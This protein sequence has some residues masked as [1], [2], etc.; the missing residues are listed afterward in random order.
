MPLHCF[1]YTEKEINGG[2]QST[3]EIMFNFQERAASCAFKE[4]RILF[5]MTMGPL[6][7]TKIR[8]E[9]SEYN[10]TI[11]YIE[12]KKSGAADGLSRASVHELKIDTKKAFAITTRATT[13]KYIKKIKI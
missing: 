12:G 2:L 3:R 6:K 9:L 1:I 7:L 13:R 5:N 4:Y 8:L 10:F 11:E